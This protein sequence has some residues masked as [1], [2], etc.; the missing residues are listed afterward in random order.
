MVKRFF[1]KI[2]NKIRGRMDL[3]A[4]QKRGLV[5]GK[6]VFVNYGCN[7]DE[8]FCWL[9]KIGNNV[10]FGPNVTVLTHDAS[11]KRVLGYTKIGKVSIG[12]NVF[13]GAGSIILPGVTVEDNVIIGA[14]SVVAKD[15]PTNSVVAGVPAQKLCDYDHYVDKNK[16]LLDQSPKYESYAGSEQKKEIESFLQKNKIG[17]IR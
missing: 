11:T 2:I 14:G 4:L 17:F 9:I 16:A 7:F 13:V 8:S 15:V 1:E 12:N 10:T 3:P 6:N 5:M